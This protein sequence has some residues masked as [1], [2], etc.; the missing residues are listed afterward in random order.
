[1]SILDPTGNC[2][3]QF[4][5]SGFIPDVFL[6]VYGDAC[7]ASLRLSQCDPS[8]FANVCRDRIRLR[9]ILSLHSCRFFSLFIL[10]LAECIY[11]KKIT[12][13]RYYAHLV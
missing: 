8:G 5:A 7:D 3:Y 12:S 10:S 1:M 2:P 11:S 13:I 9:R 4:V 6:F